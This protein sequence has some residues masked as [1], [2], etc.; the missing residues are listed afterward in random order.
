MPQSLGLNLLSRLL[1]EGRQAD[2]YSLK[3]EHFY[4]SEEQ[5]VYTWVK[6]HVERHG[7]LPTLTYTIAR[8]ALRTTD[9]AEPYGVWYDDYI[10]RAIYNQFGKL[11]PEI[12]RKLSNPTLAQE[13]LD[14]VTAFV[15]QTHSIRTDSQRDVVDLATVGEEVLAEYRRLRGMHGLSGIPSRLPTLDRTTHGYQR[16]DLIV[17]VARP[18]VGKSTIMAYMARE[19]HRA[20]FRPLFV[21]ME[22]KRVQLGG[23]LF[24]IMGGMDMKTLR[25]GQLTSLG[26]L[27]LE[28]LIEEARANPVPFYFVEGQ[29]R[30]SV[31]ELSSLVHSLR[32]DIM[33]VDGAYLL[34]LGNAN[35]RM[36]RWDVIAEL[37]QYLKNIAAINNIPVVVSFQINRE[38]G[39]KDKTGKDTGVEHIQ[40]SDAIGQLASLVIGIFEDDESDNPDAD[41]QRRLRILKGREGERGEWVVNW[42]FER[43]DF[44]EITD[45]SE[46]YDENAVHDVERENTGVL[47]Q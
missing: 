21:S 23:R 7:I 41:S 22:M 26:E 15:E 43:M 18:G 2:F 36:P 46:V 37:A 16:G 9:S 34:K 29:F 12:Q 5:A 44:T 35:S 10:N 33:F 40:L 8:T 42:N 17:F 32:P 28:G 19:A 20:G 6:R 14:Q 11:L 30:K 31:N 1:E 39:K 45:G 25:K 4:G 27:K 47:F 38:G 3:E 24:A 13:A